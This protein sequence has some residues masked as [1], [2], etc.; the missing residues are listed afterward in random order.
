MSNERRFKS[1]TSDNRN[2]N[3][4]CSTKSLNDSIFLAEKKNVE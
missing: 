3:G 2:I 4:I 1:L